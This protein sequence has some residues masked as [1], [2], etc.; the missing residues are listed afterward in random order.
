MKFLT[1]L[2]LFIFSNESISQINK[3]FFLNENSLTNSKSINFLETKGLPSVPA[4]SFLLEADSK[5]DYDLKISKKWKRAKSKKQ[6]FISN[7]Q[8]CRCREEVISNRIEATNFKAEDNVTYLGD[9]RGKYLYKVTVPLVKINGNTQEYLSELKVTS[10]NFNF[11]KR[12]NIQKNSSEKLVVVLPTEFLS[13]KSIISDYYSNK[14]DSILFITNNLIIEN[15]R[16]LAK[17]LKSLY[18]EL[19]MS[20]VLFVG[21]SSAIPTFYVD[22]KFDSVTPSDYPYFKFGGEND[23][24]PD[25]IAS[26]WSFSSEDQISGF[27]YKLKNKLKFREN[28]AL[29]VSSNEGANP[30]DEEYVQSILA[31]VANPKNQIHLNQ[32]ETDSNSTS[33]LSY[34]NQGLDLFNYIGHGSGFSWPSFGKEVLV[35]ELEGWEPN[36]RNPI[37]IDVACQNGKFNGRGYI[38]ETMVSGHQKYDYKNGAAAYIGGSVDISWDPPAIFAQGMA[39]AFKE[40]QSIQVGK[41]MFEGF[42]HLLELH[43]DVEDFIDHLEWTHLQGDATASIR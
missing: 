32:D 33:F 18:N 3:S 1:L 11:F 39:Q 35:S 6:W 5:V 43:H 26:R 19:K 27:I 8:K 29:G 12:E 40:N 14:F 37:V 42:F 10:K 20:Q 7:G 28:R 25:V 15:R 22:T 31:S 30:S 34:L 24:I 41:A 9:Y 17:K 2:L 16:E 38:G 36:Q 13:K 21:T 23:L 4:R